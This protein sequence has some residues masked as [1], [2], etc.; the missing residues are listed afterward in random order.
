MS[1]YTET[2]RERA[3]TR[4]TADPVEAETVTN[5]TLTYLVLRCSV[6]NRPQGMRL[7]RKPKPA[8]C[9]VCGGIAVPAWR[10]DHCVEHDEC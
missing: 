10:H 3:C 6:C 7:V 5:G 9:A 2:M 8:L 4:H 1:T